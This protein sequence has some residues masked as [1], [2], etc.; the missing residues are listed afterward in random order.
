VLSF[1]MEVTHTSAFPDERVAGFNPE[2][3]DMDNPS[4]AFH[5]RI[6]AVQAETES[7]RRFIHTHVFGPE[8]IESANRL[9]DRIKAVGV[10]DP[11]YWIETYPAYGSPAWEDGENDRRESLSVAIATGQDPSPFV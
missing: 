3:A 10:I 11:Q 8:E 6:I 7:G 9:A 2:M 5:E 4:G 1:V